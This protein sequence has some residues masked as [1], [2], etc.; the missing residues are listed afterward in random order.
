M[1][2]Q[3]NIET[4]TNGLVTL[5]KLKQLYSGEQR[6]GG[7]E[8]AAYIKPDRLSLMQEIFTAVASFIPQTRGASYSAAFNQGNRYSSAYRELKRHI[9][10][11]DSRAPGHN[12]FLKTLKLI[13]PVLNNRQKVY[14]DKVLKIID[15]LNS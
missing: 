1:S 13:A 3:M 2:N 12:Q 14:M 4:I 6:T 9:R 10:S 5:Q 8:D 15:I 7:E 11:V